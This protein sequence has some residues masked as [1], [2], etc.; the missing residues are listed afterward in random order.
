MQIELHC[1]DCSCHFRARPEMPAGEVL[2][3]MTDAGPWFALAEGETFEDMI[4]AAL[5]GRGRI[6]CP[7]CREPVCVSE[8]T[9]GRYARAK[10]PCC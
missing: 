1:P 10:F 5:L 9:L 3:R 2:N 6:L 8:R 4:F 7:E